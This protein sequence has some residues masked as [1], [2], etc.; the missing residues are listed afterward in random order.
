FVAFY[1]DATDLLPSATPLGYNVFLLERATGAVTLVSHTS[2]GANIPGNNDSFGDPIQISADG[3]F[4]AFASHATDLVPNQVDTNSFFLEPSTA[5]VTMVSHTPPS[6]ATTAYLAFSYAGLVSADGGF[7]AFE[8]PATN[9][10]AGQSDV[11]GHRDVFLFE[12]ATGVVTLISHS[13]S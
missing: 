13:S 6:R 8:S 5:R 9:L 1:S 7:V 12:R 11:N 10:V 4:V 2:A 3:A